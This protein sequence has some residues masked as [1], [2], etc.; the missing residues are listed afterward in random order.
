MILV[1][2]VC[3]SVAVLGA[4]AWLG[5]MVGVEVGLDRGR[6]EAGIAA[7]LHRDRCRPR[8]VRLHAVKRD[9]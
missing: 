9:R 6:I 4:A 5:Y 1:A 8:N 2:L 3:S 7:A